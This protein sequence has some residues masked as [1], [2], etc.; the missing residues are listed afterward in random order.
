ML[1]LI[2]K[3]LCCE[4]ECGELR[5]GG[6]LDR[7][8]RGGVEAGPGVEYPGTVA[9]RQSRYISGEE[10]SHYA[11]TK[12][13]GGPP[14]FI[15]REYLHLLLH[16]AI[17]VL[18]LTPDPSWSMEDFMILCMCGVYLTDFTVRWMDIW[19][20]ACEPWTLIVEIPAN[21]SKIL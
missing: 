8:G 10:K 2:S 11:P 13:S 4:L 15:L 16:L 21:C 19:I 12:T 7:V 5:A 3:P 14:E 1:Y 9:R 17:V 6:E 18:S 20:L